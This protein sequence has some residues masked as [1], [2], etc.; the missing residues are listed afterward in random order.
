[1]RPA[2]MKNN[3]GY[4]YASVIGKRA[5]LWRQAGSGAACR[6]TVSRQPLGWAQQASRQLDR[7][8]PKIS[9]LTCDHL[10]SSLETHAL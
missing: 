2:N 5:R 7:A 8:G 4:V 10:C 3:P 6:L 1:M 9:R